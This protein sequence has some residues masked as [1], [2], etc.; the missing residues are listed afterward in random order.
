MMGSVDFNRHKTF[1][2]YATNPFLLKDGHRKVCLYNPQKTLPPDSIVNVT[3]LE[4]FD[5]LVDEKNEYENFDNCNSEYHD[6]K[7]HKLKN[8]DPYSLKNRK[9]TQKG[10]IYAEF[11]RTP[12]YSKRSSSDSEDY[13]HEYYNK[14][15]RPRSKPRYYKP[16]LM[17]EIP[18]ANFT[19]HAKFYDKNKL[20]YNYSN[21][22]KNISRDMYDDKLNFLLEKNDLVGQK[23]KLL[24]EKQK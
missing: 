5:V 9:E 22:K 7:F 3:I 11:S 6:A 8:Y 16:E 17:D 19:E 4:N 14:Y 18:H 20:G 10:A 12:R 21:H 2:T 23:D 13:N 24:R 15:M 1:K